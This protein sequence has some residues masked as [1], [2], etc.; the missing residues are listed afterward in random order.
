MPTSRDFMEREKSAASSAKSRVVAKYF[1]AWAKIVGGTVRG[2]L[3]YGDLFAGAG[4]HGED[5]SKG[6]A[7]MVLDSVKANPILHNRIIFLLNEGHRDSA[8]RLRTAVMEH[9]ASKLLVSH[10]VVNASV[11][12][13]NYQQFI[14][15]SRSLPTFWFLDPTGWKGLSL[16]GLC[17]FVD[18]KYSDLMFFFSY[19]NINR[20]IASQTSAEGSFLTFF[21]MDVLERIR[22]R[23]K[24]AQTSDE[25]ESVIVEEV[26]AYFYSRGRY[27]ECMRFSRNLT[28]STPH[29]LIVVTDHP[30]GRSAFLDI[31]RKESNWNEFGVARMG[32]RAQSDNRQ[33]EL[34]EDSEFEQVLEKKLG[35][36]FVGMTL[37]VGAIIGHFFDPAISVHGSEIKAA[38]T[39]MEQARRVRIQPPAESR[40]KRN[41]RLTLADHCI[42]SFVGGA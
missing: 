11:N 40:P 9:Y 25:R 38:L 23:L 30:R 34:F 37:Q 22:L 24:D 1:T 28:D 13:G 27:S 16:E 36:Q 35:S 4:Y 42:V 41:G 32:F 7:L 3:V 26:R 18:A 6:T 5:M 19:E 29:Y 39:R 2:Q 10:E 20:F 14:A 17:S 12:P 31:A 8:Q 33:L 15:Q 21:G